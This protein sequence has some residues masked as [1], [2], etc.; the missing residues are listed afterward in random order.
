MGPIARH[1]NR[2]GAEVWFERI[3]WSY[4]PTHTKGWV[5]TI[6]GTLLIAAAFWVVRLVLPAIGYPNQ[7]VWAYIVLPIGAV[8]GGWFC[9]RHSPDRR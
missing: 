8:A 2:H 6:G 7:V 5:T 1:I 3:F 9:E 4:W